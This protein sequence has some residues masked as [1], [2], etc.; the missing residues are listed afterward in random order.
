MT[1]DDQQA[2][3]HSPEV[4]IVQGRQSSSIQGLQLTETEWK[5]DL[6]CSQTGGQQP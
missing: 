2:R 3:S 5:D 4:A 1:I 6:A